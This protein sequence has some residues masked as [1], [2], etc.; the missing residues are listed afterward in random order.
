VNN[1]DPHR[2]FGLVSPEVAGR[3]SGVEFLQSLLDGTHP[4]PPF[5]EVA[6]VWPISVEVGRVAFEASPSAR[7]YNP[8]GLV[9]GGWLALLLDSAMGCRSA[10]DPRAGAGLHDNRNEDDLRQAGPREHGQA[11]L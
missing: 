6:A 4:A 9:H 10:F 8:M 2:E 3:M 5:S 11:A 1:P 7:F